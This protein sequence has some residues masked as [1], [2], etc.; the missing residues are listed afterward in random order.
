MASLG[1]QSVGQWV[2]PD[3]DLSSLLCAG[4]TPGMLQEQAG[5][6]AEDKEFSV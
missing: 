3:K 4:N 5:G 1:K 6:G 2:S